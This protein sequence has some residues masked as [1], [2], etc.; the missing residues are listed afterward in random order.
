MK[1]QSDDSGSNWPTRVWEPVGLSLMCSVAG[2]RGP[3]ASW[4]GACH[5]WALGP[6]TAGLGLLLVQQVVGSTLG[7]PWQIAS[8]RVAHTQLSPSAPC[9]FNL[10]LNRLPVH[11]ILLISAHSSSLW[12]HFWSWLYRPAF[13]EDHLSF[14]FSEGFICRM[15][16]FQS[17]VK[18]TRWRT[19][20]FGMFGG[21]FL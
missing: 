18:H 13:L 3:W 11:L 16:P 10:L 15:A 2:I 8:C 19:W 14:G 5:L 4:R 6:L 9:V 21:F 17:N 12:R 20:S 1:T 7:Q